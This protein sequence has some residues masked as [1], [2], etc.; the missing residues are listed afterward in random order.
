MVQ[1]LAVS[2]GSLDS[3]IKDCAATLER[4]ASYKLPPSLDRRLLWLSENKET[5]THEEREELQALVDLA[6]DRTV[7]KLQ[8]SVMLRSLAEACPQLF[9]TAP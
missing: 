8:A 5:L 3:L 2:N 7:E 6:E 1:K 9:G 4:V